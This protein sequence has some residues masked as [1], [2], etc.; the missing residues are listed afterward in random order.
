[1]RLYKKG[2]GGYMPN[3]SIGYSV[4]DSKD[5]VKDGKIIGRDVT[6]WILHEYSPVGVGMNPFAQTIKDFLAAED[7][8]KQPDLK[9]A[10]RWFGF[11]DVRGKCE[12]CKAA[13]MVFTNSAGDDIGIAC[14]NCQPEEFARL[15]EAIK[16]PLPKC[17]ACGD[18]K[19]VKGELDGKPFEEPCP[20]CCAA[21]PDDPMKDINEKILLID[22]RTVNLPAAIEALKK[23]LDE[24]SKGFAKLEPLLKTL[25]PEPDGGG[26][27]DGSQSNPPGT[28]EIPLLVFKPADK[29]EEARKKEEREQAVAAVA[30]AIA[31]IFKAQIDKIMGRVP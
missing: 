16:P 29:S 25:P 15:T 1:M 6:K 24:M 14:E 9:E 12:T 22:E 21:P 28:E 10:P 18:T 31:P 8:G 23:S 2:K 30:K 5:L 27:G 11:V 20:K 19:V 26:K 3:W 7:A 13:V 17:A 4:I